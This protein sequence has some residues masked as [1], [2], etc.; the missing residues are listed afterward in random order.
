MMSISSIGFPVYFYPLG[1]N[2]GL[3][4]FPSCHCD[5]EIMTVCFSFTRVTVMRK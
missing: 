4:Q 5:E 1:N 3:F 2:D